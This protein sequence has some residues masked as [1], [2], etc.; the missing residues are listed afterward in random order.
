VTTIS[1]INTRY[2]KLTVPNAESDIVGR[3]LRQFGEWAWLEV[4]FVA[5][6]LPK[7]NVRVLDGGAFL[8]TFG[9][10]LERVTSVD[11]IYFVEA[12]PAVLPLL[13]GNAA[14][15]CR[16]AWTVD[17]VMLAAPDMEIGAPHADVD[18]LGS[19]SFL[20][21]AERSVSQ[22]SFARTT[23]CQIVDKVGNFD[24]IKLD[25]EGSE[26]G[27]LSADRDYLAT[28]NTVIWVECNE[29]PGSFELAEL[30]LSW[31]RAVYYFAF[32]AHN[33]DNKNGIDEPIFPW[34]Y[35]AGLLA[36]PYPVPPLSADMERYGCILRK[37]SNLTDLKNALWRTPRWGLAEWLNRPL[38]EVVAL[39]AH[40][41]HGD[42][43]DAFPEAEPA[44]RPLVDEQLDNV[45]QELAKMTQI[46]NEMRQREINSGEM[47]Q[48]ADMRI[49]DLEENRA[50]MTRLSNELRQREVKSGEM[51][52]RAN[53]RITDLEENLARASALALD[54]LAV[55]GDIKRQVDE[56]K[57]ETNRQ[58]AEEKAEANRQAAEEKAEAKRQADEE[59]AEAKRQADEE[60]AEAIRRLSGV[61]DQLVELRASE[62]SSMAEKAAVIEQMARG[63][64]HLDEVSAHLRAIQTSTY[65]RAGSPVRRAAARVPI[66]RRML[67]ATRRALAKI[68]RPLRRRSRQ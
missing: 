68:T 58:A 39:A 2:G 42:N 23:L 33:P 47:L 51:L 54:R 7:R 13:K 34:A 5:S 11:Y 22:I 55:I 67:V 9:L 43:L 21:V 60:T 40:K 4:L 25:I 12:N 65:W 31:G 20:A 37:I 28:Q 16:T 48:R 63:K 50:K 24:L 44:Y 30:L 32:P 8:G 64:A 29:S 45:R 62:R 59:K 57:A 15:N 19:T 56:E 27:V 18:N 35:E 61:T 53:M 14:I 6:A 38:P 36:T 49:A 10:G 52:Q 46:S 41:L 26:F 1:E 66:V 17:E 3:H